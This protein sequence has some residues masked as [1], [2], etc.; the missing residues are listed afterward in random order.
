MLHRTADPCHRM[1]ANLGANTHKVISNFG[2]VRRL[3]FFNIQV[4]RVRLLQ[5]CHPSFKL[6]AL[7]GCEKKNASGVNLNDLL[8]EN[9]WSG[10]RTTKRFY[11]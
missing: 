5:S 3:C 1:R 6:L 8:T 10:V 4:S 11:F 7:P 2:Q 9:K